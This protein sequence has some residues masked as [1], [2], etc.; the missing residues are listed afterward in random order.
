[1]IDLLH[2]GFWGFGWQGAACAALS[3]LHRDGAIVVELDRGYT[4]PKEDLAH[5]GPGLVPELS[6]QLLPSLLEQ[7]SWEREA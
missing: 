5:P 7:V 2:L 4:V 6:H 1:M 3:S